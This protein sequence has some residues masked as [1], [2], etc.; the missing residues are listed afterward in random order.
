[1][2]KPCYEPAHCVV[3][4]HAQSHVVADGESL[5]AELDALWSFHGDRLRA[6]VP[7]DR[8]DD[9]VT[10]T[11]PPP[12]R[13]VCCDECGLLY[14]N[15]AERPR[16]LAELYGRSTLTVDAMRSL[17]D[18]QRRSFRS[19]ARIVRA[20]LGRAGTG[21]EVGSYVGAFLAAAQHEGLAFEGLDINRD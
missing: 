3:C 4:G 8:L 7:L 12:W 18:R 10:F 5:R 13:L 9:R 16:V 21:L 11:E 2:A 17:H 20:L 14:R 6:A 19:Q 1:M 15:P